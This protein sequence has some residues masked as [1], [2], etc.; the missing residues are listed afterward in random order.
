[1]VMRPQAQIMALDYAT[2]KH[3]KVGN[4]VN[5]LRDAHQHHALVVEQDNQGGQL[6][7]EMFSLSLLSK[8]LNCDYISD[9]AEA[10]SIVELTSKLEK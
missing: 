10:R 4:I 8:Q 2:L 3:A 5:T 7:R 1:M 6:V 9:V